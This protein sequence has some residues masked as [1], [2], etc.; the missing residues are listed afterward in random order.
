MKD[1]VSVNTEY[2]K[3]CNTAKW[4]KLQIELLFFPLNTIRINFKMIQA[5][6]LKIQIINTE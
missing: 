2:S 1:T 5:P 3:R 4:Y 6:L